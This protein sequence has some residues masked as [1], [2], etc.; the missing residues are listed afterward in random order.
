MTLLIG[1][2]ALTLGWLLPYHFVP[3][4]TFQQEWLAAVGALLIGLAVV[5]GPSRRSATVEWP[6]LALLALATAC[7]PA[8]QCAFGQIRFVGDAVL[9]SLYLA[10]FAMSI[11]AGAAL[12]RERPDDLLGG[13][14]GSFLAAG[15]VSV[16]LA[17]TQWLQMGPISFI[18]GMG[19]GGQ[20]YANLAQPNHLASLL[21]LATVGLLWFYETRRIG[22]LA[23]SVALAWLGFGLAMTQSRTA[24]LF[25]ALLAGTTLA[26][27]RR[28]TLRTSPA[29]VVSA[30][31]YFSALVYSW[32]GL[33]ETMLVSVTSLGQRLQS[34]PRGLLW[35]ALADAV[36]DA[37][38]LGY[39]WTQVGLAT[40]AV[41]L[42]HITGRG[43]FR[44]SH[45]LVLDLWLWNG[46]PL[47][48]LILLG[49]AVWFIAQLRRCRSPEQWLML[50]GVTAVFVHAML[51]YPLEYAYFLLP[52]GLLM[53]ALDGLGGTPRAWHMPS[54]TF[55]I[56]IA[57]AAGMLGWVGV[58]YMAVEESAR[59][60]RMVMLRIGLDKV[61]YVPPPEVRLLDALREFH[62]FWLTPARPGMTT[63]E[64]DWMR[65]VQERFA[66]PPTMLR[67]ALAAALNER[68]QEASDT[69]LRLCF[70]NGP[71]RCSEGQSSWLQ[72]QQQYPQLK[73]VPFP[74]K[75][76]RVY[77]FTE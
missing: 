68:S 18:T 33:S 44:N 76:N 40:Q 74:Q 53:G 8:L 69:L 56:S 22:V 64:L 36:V 61:S 49:L 14:F 13:L 35:R 48:S 7:V 15:I 24:W 3:W 38:W 71:A 59:Q 58:E 31:L 60:V 39:G 73:V 12:V 6:P 66:S 37:P 67:Y 51:E 50:T 57:I 32:Q 43:Q 23:A 11:V 30:V 25:V 27:R 75:A 63:A 9:A 77:T 70:M 41:S 16:G 55:G 10:G 4:V 47:G 28:T 1:F 65:S 46:V 2:V 26:M 21:A 54:W 20:A 29:A 72:L 19:R 45:N 52:A 42:E 34:G 5:Y 62:R 17:T